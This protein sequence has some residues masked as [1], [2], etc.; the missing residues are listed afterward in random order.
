MSSL[1]SLLESR[2]A[3]AGALRGTLPRTSIE[4]YETL[5]RRLNGELS[6]E[7]DADVWLASSPGRTEL[8]GNHTDHNR[9]KVLAAS[10]DLDSVAAVS[11]R[12]DRI[13]RLASEG[14]PLVEVDLSDTAAR[15]EETGSTAA[16]VRGVAEGFRRNGHEVGGFSA[17]ASSTVLPGSGLSSSA[18]IEVLI[19]VIFSNLYNDG[20]VGSTEIATIG[21]FA[22]NSYFGKPSGLMDQVACAT[23]GAIAIDFA[24]AERPRIDHVDVSFDDAGLA[25]LVVDTG[26]DHADLTDE[27]AAIPADMGAV[28][29]ALGGQVL[30]DLDAET[31]FAAV[32]LLRREVGDRPVA[33]AIHYYEENARVD[34]MVDALNNGDLTE[35]L[36]LMAESGRSS[37]MYL[38]NCVP[39][40]SPE[41]QGVVVALALTERFFNIAGLRA[42]RDAA[43]RVHGGGF[44]GTI[45]AILPAAQVDRYISHISEYLGQRSVTRLAIRETGAIALRG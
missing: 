19:G 4:R 42:G 37:G 29:K 31:F 41:K 12:D 26:S 5:L 1:N 33:R 35:Y 27:Y 2:R 34:R 18:S 43:C 38:Q 45:Q 15:D 8:A 21:K 24:D 28:A 10:V 20:S 17:T 16:L 3:I 7:G 23:G 22:E 44:A 32:P 25:L 30:R 40:S 9:G 39:V 6:V 36:A 13:V 11:R 14:F